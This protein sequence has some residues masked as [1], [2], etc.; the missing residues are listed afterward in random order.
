MRLVTY[1]HRGS[2]RAGVLANELVVDL[3]RAGGLPPT[4]RGFLALGEQGRTAAERAVAEV[5]R[6]L[7]DEEQ[8]LL[9]QGVVFGA[10]EVRFAPPVPDPEKIIC[11]GRNYRAHAEE[12][13]MQLPEAPEL[14]AKYA[15]ALCG[16]E[17]PIRIPRVTDR[18]DYEAELA[19][20]VGRPGRYI[21]AAEALHHVAGYTCFHDVSARD[22]QMRTSQWLAGKGFDGFAPMGPWLVTRDEVVDPHALRISL[23]IGSEV[24]QDSNTSMM[25][26]KIPELIASISRIMTLQPGD[27]IATGT[28]EGVGFTRQP[29]RFLRPGDQV[30]VSIEGVGELCN[31]VQAE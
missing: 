18:V 9:D 25:V 16:H 15:N 7:P 17:D 22:F 28:P 10:A 29:P 4:L 8:R 5:E 19:V 30:V 13:G 1:R 20:V 26:F 24:L 27:I 11:L 21:E 6:R 31:P 14:F 23:R 3:E 2:Q 12:A